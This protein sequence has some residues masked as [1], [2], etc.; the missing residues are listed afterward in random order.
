MSLSPLPSWKSLIF[1]FIYLINKKSPNSK[2]WLNN[3]SQNYYWFSRSAY[4][5]W[6]INKWWKNFTDNST[7]NIWIPNYFCDEPLSLLRADKPNFYFYPIK[8]NLTPD[9]EKCYEKAS[10]SKISIFILVHYFGKP[11]E[12]KNAR[13]FCDKNECILVEDSAHVFL[14]SEEIGNYGDFTLYSPHKFLPI[15]DGSILVQNSKTNMMKKLSNKNPTEI[16]SEIIDC[17]PKKSPNPYPWI[18]KKSLQ[19][20][21]PSFFLF[22]NIKYKTKKIE[23]NKNINIKP[24]QSEYSKALLDSLELSYE[25]TSSL[26]KINKSI[27]SLNINSDNLLFNN[28]KYIPYILGVKGDVKNHEKIPFM[29][30]PDLPKEVIS[31]PLE[32]SI[33]INLQ[34]KTLFIPIHQTLGIRLVR[35]ISNDL[36]S[37]KNP[38]KRYIIEEYLDNEKNWIGLTNCNNL[39]QSWQY[40]ETK[41]KVNRWI[42]RRY[43]IKEKDSDKTLAFFQILEKRL[44]FIKINRLNRGPIFLNETTFKEKL[45]IYKELRKFGKWW[46]GKVL[47]IAPDLRDDPENIGLLHYNKF[48]KLNAKK[49][50]S[51]IINLSF[52]DSDLRKNLNGKWRNQL[53]KSENSNINIIHDNSKASL[54]KLLSHYRDLMNLNSFKGS[55]IEFYKN[56]FEINEQDFHIFWAKT[57]NEI[58]GGVLISANGKYCSYQIGWNSKIGRS[59]YANNFL[60]WNTIISMKRKGYLWFDMGGLD[61]KNQAGITRFKRGVGGDEYQ[62]AGEWTVY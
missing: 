8:D 45:L 15:P 33:A 48:K 49:W 57:N 4:S 18:I 54:N 37:K 10:K 27:I 1:S 25:K 14:P 40:G 44:F 55:S 43:I 47:L 2:K 38:Y 42:A 26:R 22:N 24:F 59:L 31:N 6:I 9:W 35:K 61:T 5:L 52:S 58:I 16:L 3:K 7:S 11:S 12:G 56:L 17:L 28:R 34:K 36:Y 60:I 29:K 32:N 20:L 13:D 53:K 62:L 50:H 19:K 30:W 41:K 21:I 46:K 39:M 23:K 51:S